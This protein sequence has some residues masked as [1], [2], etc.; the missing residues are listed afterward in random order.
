[1]TSCTVIYRSHCVCGNNTGEEERGGGGGGEGG[2]GGKS[3]RD[4][5]NIPIIAERISARL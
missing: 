1:M 2:R 5:W 4:R 3:L